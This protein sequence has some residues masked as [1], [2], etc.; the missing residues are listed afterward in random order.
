MLHEMQSEKS[1]EAIVPD[2]HEPLKGRRSH[3]SGRD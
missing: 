2:S 1:A 3:K